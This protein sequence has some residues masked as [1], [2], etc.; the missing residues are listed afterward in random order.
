MTRDITDINIKVL[1]TLALL[2]VMPAMMWRGTAA[3]AQ[4][5]AL[6]ASVSVVF[7]TAGSK[8]YRTVQYALFKTE[9]RARGVMLNLEE[10]IKRQRGD[11]GHM[12][13]NAW[14][15][16]IARD[17]VRFRTSRGNGNFKVH[18]YPDMAILV[19]TYLPE[20]ELTVEDARFAV[21]T[22]REGQGEYTHAFK[23]EIGKGT[24]TISNVDVFGTN[25]DT[26]TIKAAPPIDDGKNM[27]F[28]I[29]VELPVGYGNEK[30]RLVVQPMAVD[31]QTEDTVDYVSGLVMEGPEYH[32]LQNKRMLYDYMKYDKVAYAYMDKP[33]Y[34][35][36]KVYIDTTLVYRKPEPRKTYKIPYTVQIADLN[37][38]YFNRSASTGSCNAK[39]IFK[40]IDLGVAAASMD[41]DE[42]YV[43]AESNYQT[44]NQDLRLE[45]IVGK[46]ELTEDSVNQR[47]LNALIKEL[48]SYGDQLMEVR[49]EATASPEGGR[50]YNQ[51][52]A[53]ARTRVAAAR[54][55]SYL[56]DVD[57][58]FHTAQPRVYSWEDVAT[59]LERDGKDSIATEVR[60]KMG[61][62]GFG[63]DAEI[64][65]MNCYDGEI[66]P[67]LERLRMMRVTY[68][69]EKEHVMDAREVTMEYY[70]RKADL[71]KG[72]GRDFSDGDYFNLFNTITDSLE[73][74]TLTMLAY[75]HIT[76]HGGYE[77]VKFSMYVANR[78]A[79]LNQRRGRP[80]P[81]VLAPFINSRLRAVATKEYGERAQKNRREVII[82]QILTYFQMEERDSALSYCAYWFAEDH[83]PKVERLR[84]YITF[85]ED[86]VKY[87]TRQLTLEQEARFRKAMD[88]VISCAKD[89]KAV[90]YTEARDILNV[91]YNVARGLVDAMDD[92]NPKKWYLRGILEADVEEKSLSRTRPAEY[93]PPYLAFFHRSF[94][95]EPTY[96][97]LYFYDGQISDEL[98]ERYKYNKNHKPR[99]RDMF[100][101]LY[102]PG[103]MT[104]PQEGDEIEIS[105][106]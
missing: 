36:E 87:A 82:N 7:E 88:Y 66:A 62:E 31:C 10:A 47:Q 106:E 5:E 63:G 6:D 23:G 40:F 100:R 98:R 18:A 93:I 89:N 92:D 74:D 19:T 94:E 90:I 38:I 12:E 105:G 81:A 41:V 104:A 68:R 39:N 64:I 83:D 67:V 28:K 96:K 84:E 97:W 86:F 15:E 78:M 3:R 37:H 53:A 57:V 75:R 4:G 30:G 50:D 76:K 44:K 60:R 99:Y 17:R 8:E 85:K 54:V 59:E 52:L 80:D 27:Y 26:I 45:F 33:M 16:A 1:L 103:V 2:A 25:R 72:Q 69:Y 65:G 71:L 51:R 35:D 73:Q 95:L 11:S 79:M 49:V 20:D 29:H 14:S 21:I 102:T 101:N 91:P 61:L 32:R 56:G 46:S 43:D 42:F 24:H 48:R 22:L 34:S 9:N 70:R 13:M 77:Q 58:A 55:R